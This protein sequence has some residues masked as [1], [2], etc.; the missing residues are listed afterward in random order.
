MEGKKKENIRSF[1]QIGR[2]E[3]FKAKGN[4]KKMLNE[5]QEEKCLII[6]KAA[7]IRYFKTK[8]KRTKNF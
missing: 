1:K 2:T 8:G 4:E 7:Y 6:R 3:A 5:G